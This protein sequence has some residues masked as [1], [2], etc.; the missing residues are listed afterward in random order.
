MLCPI[1]YPVKTTLDIGGDYGVSIELPLLND[2]FSSP[3]FK[4]P[5]F[6]PSLDGYKVL[7]AGNITGYA[8]I[9][10]ISRNEETGEAKGID[11]NRGATEY[12]WGR[13]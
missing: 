2:E 9:E 6:S 4:N 13:E 8:A 11:S 7:D 1:I 3:K 5:E 12:P 10:T